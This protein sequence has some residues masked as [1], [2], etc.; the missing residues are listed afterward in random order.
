MDAEGRDDAFVLSPPLLL[1]RTTK[2]SV[3]MIVAYLTT[4]YS[5]TVRTYTSG[6]F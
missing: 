5:I 4:Q 6:K 3:D 1:R 2:F